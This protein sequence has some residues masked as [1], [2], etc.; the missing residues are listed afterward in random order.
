M[1]VYR[2][3]KK[4]LI[5]GPVL[6]RSG[7]GEHA[8]FVVDALS[9]DPELDL[10]I[11]P[12]RWG[13]SSWVSGDITKRAYYDSLIRKTSEFSGTY[14]L[15]LQVTVPNEWSKA[16][17]INIGVTAGVETDKLINDWLPVSNEMD[18]IIVTSKHIQELF[19]KSHYTVQNQFSGEP[20]SFKGTTTPVEVVTYPVKKVKPID[21]SNQ[22][23]LDTEFNFLTVGQIAPRKN[24]FASIEWFIEEFRN[25]NVGLVVKSHMRNTSTPDGLAVEHLL[26]QVCHNSG[27][28]QCKVYLVKGCM[29]EDEVHGL[30]THPKIKCIVSTTHGEGFGLPL[31]EAAYCGLPVVAPAWS[32]QKDFLYMPVKNK[33]GKTKI[34]AQF[35]KVGFDIKEVAADA[36]MEGII[37]PDMKWCYPQKDKFQKA[38]RRIYTS[39]S[40]AEKR[41]SGLQDYLC[42]RFS[43]ENQHKAMRD[44]VK[45]TYQNDQQ[46]WSEWINRVQEV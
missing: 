11:H 7:Y 3:M 25:E 12:L 6:T 37:T 42:D 34:E 1:G 26:K 33:A 30:Y 21:L 40:L 41:A 46:D 31:Y 18:K 36:V 22:I 43:L 19:E 23:N 9:G 29:S 16:A 24:L 28:R 8:R 2:I 32:G 4:V 15:S 5:I 13:E 20:V 35:E 44:A 27:E 14:D 45:N 39:Y 17:T 10:Y 38:L